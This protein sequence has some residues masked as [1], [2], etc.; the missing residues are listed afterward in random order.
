MTLPRK[1]KRRITVEGDVYVWY[2]S[3]RFEH[4]NRWMVIQKDGVGGQL[5][6]VDPYHHDLPIG[7]KGISH[8][9][10]F[11]LTHGW[12]PDDKNKPMRLKYNGDDYDGEPF[13]II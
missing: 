2:L 13:A 5:L 4:H 8:A 1:G 7:P 11:A 10:E 3:K 12:V 6:C 9:I